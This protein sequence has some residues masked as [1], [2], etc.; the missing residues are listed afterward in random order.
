M[1]VELYC[2]RDRLRFVGGYL[3]ETKGER[4]E[5]GFVKSSRVK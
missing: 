4:K 2:V 5:I 1:K 3:E